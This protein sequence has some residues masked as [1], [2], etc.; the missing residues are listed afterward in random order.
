MADKDSQNID[1]GEIIA[2]KLGAKA[3]VFCPDI[4]DARRRKMRGKQS[5]IPNRSPEERLEE[6]I[7]LAEAIEL[8]VVVAETVRLSNPRAGTLF[9]SGVI[10]RLKKY[11]DKYSP[12]VTI[13][14]QSLTPIQQRN[15]E[16]E[17]G[18]KVIDRTGL[19][20]EIFGARAQTAEGKLQVELAAL[21]YQRSRLVRSWTHLERQRGGFGFLGGPGES[22]L[23][24]DK[25]MIDNR[26]IKIK[27]SLK[28]VSSRRGLHRKARER[29]PF[30]VIALVGYTNAGK[31]T[32]FNQIAGADAYVEDML[33]ATL[34]PTMRALELPSGHKAIFSDTVGFISDLPTMLVN[35]FRATLEEVQAA[36]II[37]HV[38]DISHPQTDA[39]KEDVSRIM[40]SL[41]IDIHNDKRVIEVQNK[42]DI[43]SDEKR[44]E[45]KSRSDRND[46]LSA[47]SALTGKGMEELLEKIDRLMTASRV[48]FQIKAP[49]DK[50][51]KILA[52]LHE[53]GTVKE[54]DYNDDGSMVIIASI[55]KSDAERILSRFG[56]SVEIYDENLLEEGA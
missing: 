44:E 20:L 11:V 9:G 39:Q 47:V 37:L 25:R 53:R 24:L 14:D 33:F 49:S 23:E 42:I 32:L 43:C 40:K 18:C 13:I 26:I 17:W 3:L 27:K 48:L 15:L 35:A 45:L 7:G 22:Q 5:I 50:A 54:S 16:K 19:V 4:P 51:G 34:D 29:V 36:D 38:R 2:E 56:V 10:E 41:S 55:E 6:A 21:D 30:P 46:N 8:N 1:D 52:W 31:S 28:Q 12:A